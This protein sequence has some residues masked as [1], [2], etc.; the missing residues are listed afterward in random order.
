LAAANS[1]FSLL[2]WWG[3][4]PIAHAMNSSEAAFPAVEIVHMIGIVLL[5]GTA[6]LVDFRL[7][8]WRLAQ[9]PVWEIA[10]DLAPWTTT[11]LVLVLITGPL[12]LAT[13]PDRYYLATQFRFKMAS[14]LLALVFDFAV[15]RRVRTEKTIA[16]APLR[17]FT[18]LVSLV[19]WSCVVLGGRAI[20]VLFIAK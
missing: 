20:G 13:D 16:T 6:A 15:G 5:V 17:R 18:G 19:L 1:L 14:L 2:D 9:T 10:S 11:G 8:G 12:L 7:L 4:T 3:T